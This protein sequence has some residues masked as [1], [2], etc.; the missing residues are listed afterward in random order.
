[1]VA[2]DMRTRVK[3][4]GITRPQDAADAARFGADAIGLVFYAKSSRAVSVAK[5][6]GCIASLPPFV[7]TVGLFVNPGAGEVREVLSA[8]QLDVL[9][10]HGEEP[11]SFCGQFGRPYLKAIRMRL[12]VDLRTARR[13]YSDAVGLLLDTY[14]PGVPGGTGHSFDWSRIPTDLARSVVL[15]GGLDPGNVSRAIREVRPHAVDVSGGVE[16]EKGIKDPGKIAAF[17]QGVEQGDRS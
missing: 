17:M 9:Q 16:K 14:T 13:E 8:V 11:A 4:C 1:M 10:F 6:R 15:A 2:C 5:A 12:S 7:T 3:I